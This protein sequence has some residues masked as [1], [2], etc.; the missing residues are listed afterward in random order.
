M[1]QTRALKTAGVIAAFAV[2]VLAGM[3]SSS[4]RVGAR[5]DETG[6]QREEFRIQ[7]G[8]DIAPVPLNLEGKTGRSWDWAV[9]LSI[10]RATATAAT[11]QARALNL[12]TAAI[13]ISFPRRLAGKKR[14][15]RRPILAEDATLAHTVR[16]R[17]FT[18]AI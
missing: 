9:T 15:I 18:P 6:G 17:T 2:I 8:F 11:L 16:F 7:R 3:P 14:Q 1:T 5:D 12:L 10:L 13:L 4:K